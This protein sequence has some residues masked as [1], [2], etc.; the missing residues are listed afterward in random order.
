MTAPRQDARDAATALAR[1]R[2]AK[3]NA[4]NHCGPSAFESCETARREAHAALVVL[5]T[6]TEGVAGLPEWPR[7]VGVL[8]G[9][10]IDPLTCARLIASGGES[11]T[12]DDDLLSAWEEW[13]NDCPGDKGGTE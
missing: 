8:R 3:D 2:D 4:R 13:A 9:N 11:S 10:R 5:A 7:A 12:D 1:L 6:T